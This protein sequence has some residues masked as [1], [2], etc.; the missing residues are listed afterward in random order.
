MNRTRRNTRRHGAL[1]ALSVLLL[2]CVAAQG[3]STWDGSQANGL[4][5]DGDNWT[6]SGVPNGDTARAVL[7]ST[8]SGRSIDLGGARIVLGNGTTG[9]TEL[10]KL[11]DAT[12]GYTIGNGTLSFYSNPTGGGDVSIPV[13][14]DHTINASLDM[15]NAAYWMANS[16]GVIFT[17]ASSDSLTINSANITGRNYSQYRVA[18]GTTRG[19]GLTVNLNSTNTAVGGPGTPQ[20]A[21]WYITGGSTLRLLQNFTG[22]IQLQV[23]GTLEAVGTRSISNTL[24]TINAWG[25]LLVTGGNLTAGTWQAA[26]FQDQTVEVTADSL[27]ATNL[28]TASGSAAHRTLTVT[29]SSGGPITI[30]GVWELGATSLPSY[31]RNLVINRPGNVFEFASGSSTANATTKQTRITVQAGTLLVNSSAGLAGLDRITINNGATLGGTGLIAPSGP[32]GNGYITVS[33]GGIVAPGASIGTL[34]LDGA[35]TSAAVLTMNSGALFDFELDIAGG[36]PDQ[37]ELWN[38]NSGDLVLNN[39]NINFALNGT[40]TIPGTHTVTLFKFFSDNG[41]TPTASGI[42]SGLNVGTL[43]PN[44]SSATLQYNT[45]TIDLQYTVIPEPGS[46]LLL[47]V[48]GLAM[49]LRRR[50][51]EA[52]RF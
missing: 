40:P 47:G 42:S 14:G 35:G 24:R 1:I 26:E 20:T 41:S 12:N 50:V 7:D 10:L 52:A 18:G 46:V 9:L 45:N 25:P 4:W 33:S 38:Y 2:A 48:G 21:A 5:N 27:T 23:Y 30:N 13:T 51:R 31:Q 16:K 6:P 39:N 11:D 34:K 28:N 36:T 37:I 8:G 22:S 43:D 44:I 15:G 17:G 3:Q 49:L 19:T 29:G 32:S